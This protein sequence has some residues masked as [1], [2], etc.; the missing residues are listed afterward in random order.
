MKFAQQKNKWDLVKSLREIK[1]SEVGLLC[2]MVYGIH[3]V[4]C[5]GCHHCATKFPRTL[6]IQDNVGSIAKK[7]RVSV[8][9]RCV[10]EL[11]W[12][13]NERVEDILCMSGYLA[14]W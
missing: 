8:L 4:C 3:A 14:F 6:N 1:E 10:T 9:C 12:F 13:S 11:S 5:L 2:R 7:M